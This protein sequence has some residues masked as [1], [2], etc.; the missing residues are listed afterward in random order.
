MNGRGPFSFVLDT[1]AG[2]NLITTRL[3]AITGIEKAE[4]RCGTG[5]AGAVTLGLGTA[6]TFCVGDIS[7]RDSRIGI[8]DELLRIG[9]VV[10]AQIDGAVGYEFL[11]RFCVTIGYRRRIVTFSGSTGSGADG[12]RKSL[13]F[14][15]GKPEKPLIV[16]EA[17]INENGPF[18]LALD[19]GAS[20]TTLSD[21][22]ALR[23]GLRQMAIRAA[24]GAGGTIQAQAARVESIRLGDDRAGPLDV[25]V[26]NATGRVSRALGEPL[27]GILG[28]N[29][30][31]NFEV[32]IDYPHSSIVLSK[33]G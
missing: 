30:L 16:V 19:T 9:A 4:V 10:G 11:Q 25:V 28:Y 15:L 14:R 13:P 22:A 23:L 29:F 27:D 5:A 8:T 17:F 31:S 6:E 18:Q 3:A 21:E 33:T 26:T 20:T 32:V 1:G 2:L 12:R 24:T 7:V